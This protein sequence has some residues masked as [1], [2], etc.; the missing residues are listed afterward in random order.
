MSWKDRIKKAAYVAP[1]GSRTEFMFEDL[2]RKATKKGTAHEFIA[3]DGTYVQD[4]GITSR[5]FPMTLFL[6]GESCDLEATI[7]ESKLYQKGIGTLEHPLYGTVDVVTLGE[8]TRTDALKTAANQATINVEFIESIKNL[9]PTS[10]QELS[11]QIDKEV[12]EA[13]KQLAEQYA[14]NGD[15]SN[16]SAQT[17]LYQRFLELVDLIKR[18]MQDLAYAEGEAR[19]F[20][21]QFGIDLDLSITEFL[22][23]TQGA[24]QNALNM[25][26]TL[27]YS[28]QN[29]E[30]KVSAFNNFFNESIRLTDQEY[31]FPTLEADPRNFS[32][33]SDAMMG[34]CVNNLCKLAGFKEF[35]SRKEAVEYSDG[36]NAMYSNYVLKRE[37]WIDGLP[38]I[39][40]TGESS[41]SIQTATA[42]T[43]KML[44][45]RLFDLPIERTITLTAPSN[46]LNICAKYYNDISEETLIFFINT[47][48]IAGD[49]FQTLEAGSR[50]LVYV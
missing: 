30:Q 26:N 16:E 10:D 32:S 38:E 25:M 18:Y 36:L 42:L 45:K 40:D 48:R 21:D 29:T 22:A 47:N 31:D 19:A 24:M 28:A 44:V 7:L 14:K 15:V 1:D 39:T 12:S 17:S 20:F 23:D 49:Q 11:D 4:L 13:E 43:L 46:I 34:N 41:Q 37:G 50:I 3:F 27:S 35:K 8:I 33:N 5:R 9:Y 6:S 2:Q